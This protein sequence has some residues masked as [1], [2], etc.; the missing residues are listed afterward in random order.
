MID[1]PFLGI[2]FRTLSVMTTLWLAPFFAFGAPM[3]WRA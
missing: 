1:N 2:T 3:M